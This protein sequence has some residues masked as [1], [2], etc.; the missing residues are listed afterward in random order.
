[1]IV[2][3]RII[4]ISMLFF[5]FSASYAYSVSEWIARHASDKFRPVFTLSSG[6]ASA[7]VGESQTFPLIDNNIY[8]YAANHRHDSEI[9]W[10]GFIGTEM[11]F[12]RDWRIQLGVGYYQ[13]GAFKQTGLLT[14]GPTQESSDIFPYSFRTLSRQ[15]LL[16]SKIMFNPSPRYHPYF[17]VG[18]GAAFN[19]DYA[20]QIPYPIFMLFTPLFA[21]QTNTTFSYSL[22]MGVD[23]DLMTC[24]RLGLGYRFADFGK[25][26]LSPGVIDVTPITNTLQQ[27]HL[28]S[29]ILLVQLTYVLA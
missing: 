8:Q 18:L 21:S 4:V 1:M 5:S 13:P 3:S 29:Q 15:L 14:Q 7:A 19:T 2:E 6:V 27:S 11:Q 20:Y 16:E 12:K 23:V 25:N 17:S 26:E 10:G 22:G 24:L 28:Y 9:L